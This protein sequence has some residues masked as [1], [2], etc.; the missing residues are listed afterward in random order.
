MCPK[1]KPARTC[2]VRFATNGGP[3]AKEKTMRRRHLGGIVATLSGAVFAASTAGCVDNLDVGADKNALLDED[4]GTGADADTDSDTD[5][6]YGSLPEPCWAAA[7]RIESYD[8]GGYWEP[9]DADAFPDGAVVVTGRTHAT[10]TAIFGEGEENETSL[11]TNSSL[12]GFIVKYLDNGAVSWA[13][14]SAGAPNQVIALADGGVIAAGHYDPTLEPTDDEPSYASLARF[15]GDGALEWSIR[16]AERLE[17]DYGSSS[18]ESN[19]RFG[20]DALD[21]GSII[22]AAAFN[23]EIV[24]GE[25]EVNETVLSS[26][27]DGMIAAYVAHFFADG[28][29]DWA[30]LVSSD[31]RPLATAVRADGAYAVV[32]EQ[33]V[34]MFDPAGA[35]LWN[36]SVNLSSDK[37]HGAAWTPLGALVISGTFWEGLYVID[38]EGTSF[39][40]AAPVVSDGEV[41]VSVGELFV[42]GFDGNGVCGWLQS[43]DGGD[44]DNHAVAYGMDVD[45][46]GGAII[47]G[48]F[49]G[50]VT[51]GA[52]E[53]NEATITAVA[54]EDSYVARFA[55][56]G[57]LDWAVRL[58]TGAEV[59]RVETMAITAF[60]DGSVVVSGSAEG[61]VNLDLDD[62]TTWTHA[63][64]ANTDDLLTVKLCR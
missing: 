60:D 20:V 63:T 1:A 11:P 12:G 44:A 41:T 62:G 38:S 9:L 54:P 36:A 61:T 10:G 22:V 15:G 43:I 23:G 5:V 17:W 16:I 48:A 33:G 7:A 2:I 8:D 39:S 25:G 52:G 64:L 55:S 31:F 50:S 46:M 34:R 3:D 40:A 28:T 21:D 37:L 53:A 30:H 14:T 24:L 49:Y 56:G 47:T 35:P 32:G 59:T 6:E 18:G 19:P 57:A 51:L 42:V 45:A 26:G 4:S 27:G 13:T 58:Q 29:L